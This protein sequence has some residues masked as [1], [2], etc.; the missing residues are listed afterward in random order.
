MIPASFYEKDQNYFA[1]ELESGRYHEAVFMRRLEDV[2][3]TLTMIVFMVISRLLKEWTSISNYVE[4]FVESKLTFL[5]EEKQDS[6][7][8]DD[9]EFSRSRQYSW[10]ITSTGE[11]IAII[12]KTLSD[13]SDLKEWVIEPMRPGVKKEEAQK[14]AEKYKKKL[15]DV[16]QRFK[17]QKAR[18][19]AL[20]D[21]VSPLCEPRSH[22]H[23][24]I[25]QA[26]Q[27]Q[28]RS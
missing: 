4:T 16:T 18:A 25:F 28:C 24:D 1:A 9:D 13:Y 23:V 15:D 26:I 7:L 20:R 10:V 19:E 11:F 17:S 5:H 21:G 14:Q 2:L 12:E 3:G 22:L 27:C 6:L 8:F